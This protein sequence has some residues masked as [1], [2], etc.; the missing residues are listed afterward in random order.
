MQEPFE[1]EQIGSQRDGVQAK[2]HARRADL[3]AGPV[4]HLARSRARRQDRGDQWLERTLDDSANRR[5]VLPEAFLAVD[6]ILILATNVVAGPRGREPVIARHVAEQM[7]F[8]ATERWLML[9]VSAGGDRQALHEVIRTESHA[10]AAQV[11]AGGTNDLMQRL[12]GH[13]AFAGVPAARLSA[14]L[15]P[16]R[17]TG[18]SAEQVAEFLTEMLEPVIARAARFAATAATEEIRV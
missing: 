8:M 16:A 6:A 7:P 3:R 11:S 5:I 14:E 1:A 13:P 2:P 18:H 4:R 15:D 12:A 9:G 10:V 17:Y